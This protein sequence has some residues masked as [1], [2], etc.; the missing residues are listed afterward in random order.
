MRRS[1]AVALAIMDPENPYRYVAIRGRVTEITETG[2]DAHIDRLARK[3]LGVERYPHRRPGEV[4]VIYTIV[5]D[6]VSG[7]G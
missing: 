3:Y 1:S 5:P 4:R 2:A 6:R 7:M